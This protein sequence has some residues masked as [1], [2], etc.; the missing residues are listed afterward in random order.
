VGLV[1]GID[2]QYAPLATSNRASVIWSHLCEGSP[3]HQDK[4][5]TQYLRAALLRTQARA[6]LHEV[7]AGN[8]A[9]L[10]V[11][12]TLRPRCIKWVKATK[13][14]SFLLHPVPCAPY[15]AQREASRRE[16]GRSPW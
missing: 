13:T 10:I 7:E 2:G 14:A 5:A 1:P 4:F 3:L 9:D 11:A 12:D 16:K 8:S 6:A 15:T